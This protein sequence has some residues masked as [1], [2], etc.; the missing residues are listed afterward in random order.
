MKIK[1]RNRMHC[2][3]RSFFIITLVIFVQSGLLGCASSNVSREANDNVAVGYQNANSSIDNMGNGSVADSYGNMS[4]TTKGVLVGGA[5]GAVIGGVTT[6]VGALTGLASGAILGGAY[7][8][9]LD[10]N[11]TLVDQLENR[12]VKVM[13]LGDQVRLV[14][15]SSHTFIGF[16]PEIRPGVY[17]TLDLVAR[18]LNQYTTMSVRVAAYTNA[19]E[20][21]R[22]SRAI[23]KEQ[24]ESIVRYLWRK[25]VN[26]R[27]L[28]AAG[29]GGTNLVT[30]N[31][32]NLDAGWNY[33]LEIT[34]EKLPITGTTLG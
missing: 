11:T 13:V 26:T 1:K 24:A 32:M 25:G 28:T 16:T 19:T 27:M 31:S 2:N 12:G 3:I 17:S 23:S 14:M 6:G 30:E 34:A 18:F 20:S 4:Q 9:Y 7:G 15:H 21:A 10:S 29:M 5:A 8:S 22:I 33:R